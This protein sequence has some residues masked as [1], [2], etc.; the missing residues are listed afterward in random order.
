[1]TK[2]IKALLLLFFA[3]VL[4][5]VQA[6]TVTGDTYQLIIELKDGQTHVYDLA[7]KPV[8]TFEATTLQ[9]VS[10]TLSLSYDGVTRCYFKVQPKQDIVTGVSKPRIDEEVK[11]TVT[12]NFE[13]L[14][15][16]IITGM[17][18]PTNVLVFSVNGMRQ[19][20]QV[21]NTSDQI[22]INLSS[23]PSGIFVIK[24]GNQTIKI[25]R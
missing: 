25:S 3:F 6:V 8:L 11:N 16:L 24:F 2:K 14:N 9:V 22:D 10:P 4:L 19:K 15:H 5:P 7:D 1:M 17:K 23:L 12:F 13:S 20:V 21:N 18:E